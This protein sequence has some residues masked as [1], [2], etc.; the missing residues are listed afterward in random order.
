MSIVIS[1]GAMPRSI[2][3]S[4]MA[5]SS[6]DRVAAFQTYRPRWYPGFTLPVNPTRRGRAHDPTPR[7]SV[8][9]E[10]AIVRSLKDP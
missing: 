2:H 10:P 5:R 4:D 1:M 8:G 6:P 3:W 9:I 7:W